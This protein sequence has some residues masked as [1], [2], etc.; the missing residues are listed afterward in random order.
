MT[1]RSAPSLFACFVAGSVL[2]LPGALAQGTADAGANASVEMKVDTPS[3]GVTS[4]SA[5]YR[6]DFK[7]AVTA[8]VGTKKLKVWLPLAQDNRVQKISDRVIETLPRSVKHSVHT[9]PKFGNQFAYLEFDSPSGAQLITHRFDATVRQVDWRVDYQ[10]VRQPESWPKSFDPYRQID[11]RTK[12]GQ[13]LQSV[14]TEISADS[15]SSADRLVNAMRWVDDHLTYDHSVA[16]LSADPMHG[17]VHRRG[18]CSDYHGLCS[19][20]AQKVGYPSRVLY[21]L[22]MFDKASPSHCKLEVF[23]PPY[24][25]VPFDLS[26]TQKLVAKVAADSTLDEEARKQR[27]DLIRD[28]T[29]SGFRENTWLEVTRG[30]NYELAPP[31]SKPV[32][33]V[34]T[35]YVEADGV[36]LD[37]FDSTENSKPSQPW[38]TIYR[39]DGDGSGRRFQSA[40]DDS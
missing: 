37:E 6:V 4:R 22:Q 18:H 32:H 12:E 7:I 13:E 19:T 16:S 5:T 10:A 1:H 38:M 23:L 24:G 25:W 15:E 27:I 40:G 33:L 20:L 2:C 29:L 36:A 31:A 35:V 17:L 14:L 39:V 3:Q 11:P 30:T 21:G 28:R 26:E 9:E 34:R 8:P